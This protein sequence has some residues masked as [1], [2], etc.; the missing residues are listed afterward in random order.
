MKYKNLGIFLKNDFQLKNF[1]LLIQDFSVGFQK[2]L[3]SSSI[4][5]ICVKKF[6]N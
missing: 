5:F 3:T 2:D 1:L 4:A 6:S